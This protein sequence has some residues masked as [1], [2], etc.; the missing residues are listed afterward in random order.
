MRYTVPRHEDRPTREI[1]VDAH[2]ARARA[3]LARARVRARVR[4]ASWSRVIAWLLGLWGIAELIRWGNRW[5]I[6]TRF[7]ADATADADWK[8]R[9]ELLDDAH[10]TLVRALVMLLLAAAFAGAA[11]MARRSLR[12]VGLPAR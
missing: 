9:Y 5:Y 2:R 4:A 8:W 1:D 6:A 3:R 11:M 7:F 10:A 12:G